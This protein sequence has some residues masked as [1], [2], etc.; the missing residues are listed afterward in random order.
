MRTN[1]TSVL[2]KVP[3]YNSLTCGR[4]SVFELNVVI[5]M[6]NFFLFLS[7]VYKATGEEFLKIA[8]GK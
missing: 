7:K 6:C 1:H 3:K 4:V 8:G 5:F 2:L